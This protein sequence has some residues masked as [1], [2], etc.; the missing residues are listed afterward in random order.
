M[1]EAL[2]NYIHASK[3][4]KFIPELHR[5]ETFKETVLRVRRMHINRF[6]NLRPQ[7]IDAFNF[8]LAKKVLPSMRSMQFAG[9]PIIERN[10][11]EWIGVEYFLRPLRDYPFQLNELR[12]LTR[13]VSDQRRAVEADIKTTEQMIADTNEQ[14]NFRS[15]LEVLNANMS[16]YDDRLHRARGHK[17]AITSAENIR[18]ITEN[19]EMLAQK[20]KKVQDAYSLRSTPQAVGTARDTLEFVR[21]L[22][23]TEL[24]G[25]SDNP[26]F[27]PEDD[28]VISGANF[29]G[30]PIAFATEFLGMSIA[31]LSVLSER[32][33]NRLTNPFYQGR[34]V[35]SCLHICSNINAL[36]ISDQTGQLGRIN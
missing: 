32:R 34:K 31:T 36:C 21:H 8:V 33:I 27:F 4:A 24:N 25:V 15:V 10:D 18:R 28:T 16:G 13:K 12:N 9:T 26:I 29:Q 1:Q 35:N 11:A 22:I 6:P 2:S 19:S 30:S 7:I 17:G 14:K 20:G 5:R 3:Y 23:E